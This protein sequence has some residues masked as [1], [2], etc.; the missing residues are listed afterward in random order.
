MKQPGT[1]RGK[2]RGGKVVGFV[3]TP[4]AI[5]SKVE[6]LDAAIAVL[7]GDVLA[8]PTSKIGA[9]WRTEWNAFRRRWAVE[10]D[11]YA[12]W[13]ARLFATYAMPRIQAFEENY[14]WWARDF[15]KKTGTRAPV[16]SPAPSESAT[17]ALVPT[18][19]WWIVAGALAL[20]VLARR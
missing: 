6:A 20:V 8:T 2:K 15:E 10:R 16:S 18:P 5:K 12:S 14:R 3:I 9:S 19:V 13:S 1:R 11:S 7:D 17:E 4:D